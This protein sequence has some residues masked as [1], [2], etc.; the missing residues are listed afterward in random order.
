V[1]LH[2]LLRSLPLGGDLVQ[3]GVEVISRLDGLNLGLAHSGADAAGLLGVHLGGIGY[4]LRLGLVGLR[5]GGVQQLQ[6]P[7]ELG[8][9]IGLDMCAAKAKYKQLWPKS[10][11]V[12]PAIYQPKRQR[13][14]NAGLQCGGFGNIYI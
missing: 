3:T 10:G 1:L 8:E 7:V 13:D 4:E 5:V 2:L 12:M 14:I 6:I 9:Y 11:S